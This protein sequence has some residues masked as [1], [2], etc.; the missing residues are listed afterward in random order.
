MLR[1]QRE[2]E[3]T[4]F[5]VGWLA[6]YFLPVRKTIMTPIKDKFPIDVDSW[7]ACIRGSGDEIQSWTAARDVASA[8]VEL[9]KAESWVSV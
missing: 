3:W 8:V 6:D 5:N 9:C 4:L 2:V 7:I 1:A